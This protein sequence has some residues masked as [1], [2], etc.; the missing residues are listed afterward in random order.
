MIAIKSLRMAREDHPLAPVG[1][2]DGVRCYLTLEDGVE[3]PGPFL[4]LGLGFDNW[5]TTE[6]GLNGFIE[7]AIK[8]QMEKR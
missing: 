8:R 4:P 7:A 5:T 2:R 3:I 1:E 6:L